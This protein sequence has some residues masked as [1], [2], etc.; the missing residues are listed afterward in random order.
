MTNAEPGN[1]LDD[2]YPV[3]E[4]QPERV[5]TRQGHALEDLTLGN[6]LAG[7][8]SAADFAI[9]GEGLRLQAEVAERA[10][11]RNLAENLRRGA[12]LVDVPGEEL[13]KIYELL[14]PRRTGQAA[15]LRAAAT[16]L[17]ANYQAEATARLLD[18][19]AAAYE[20]RGI[21]G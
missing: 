3:G 1:A 13:L 2:L 14:R 17:R 5:R 11:R 21:A 8:V 16:R 18:E 12:E 10:G 15:E 4:K 19:A 6:L 20:R 7:E 9:T